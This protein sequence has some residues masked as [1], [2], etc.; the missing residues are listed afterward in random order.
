MLAAAPVPSRGVLAQCCWRPAS[1]VN[2]VAMVHVTATSVTSPAPM[3]AG[4]VPATEQVSPVGCCCTVTEYEP[5]KATVREKVKPAALA[6]GLTVS[7]PL[8]RIRPPA[9]RPA[10]VPPTWYALAA[11]VIW[12]KPTSLVPI[13]PL[14]EP[15]LHVSPV[16]CAS[17]LTA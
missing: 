10:S 11:H 15:T 14:P 16:G 5:P 4:N 8:A 2:V 6:A 1:K 3:V 13:V 7:V 9:V 17:T 12:T